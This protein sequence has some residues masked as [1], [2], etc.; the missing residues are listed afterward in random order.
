MPGGSAI[1]KIIMGMLKMALQIPRLNGRASVGRQVTPKGS[2]VSRSR[3]GIKIIV[4]IA[5]IIVV[6]SA[7]GGPSD[8]RRSG[9]APTSTS[10][11][12]ASADIQEDQ[13]VDIIEVARHKSS[14]HRNG[15]HAK[16]RMSSGFA[17]AQVKVK[18]RAKQGLLSRVIVTSPLP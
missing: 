11:V 2:P 1:L 10:A 17:V 3:F 15:C 9:L 6:A 7:C 5:V 16:N 4:A 12:R 14:I 18:S 13:H 8:R